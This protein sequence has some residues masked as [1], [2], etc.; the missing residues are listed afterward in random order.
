LKEFTP[1][2]KTILSIEDDGKTNNIHTAKFAS[3]SQNKPGK[4]NIKWDTGSIEEIDL[5]RVCMDVSKR[6]SRQTNHLGFNEDF[7]MKTSHAD[8]RKMKR[9]VKQMKPIKKVMKKVNTTKKITP[10]KKR[11]VTGSKKLPTRK[12]GKMAQAADFGITTIKNFNHPVMIEETEDVYYLMHFFGDQILIKK[13]RFSSK[14]RV[15]IET[16]TRDKVS[17]IL[18]ELFYTKLVTRKGKTFTYEDKSK[19]QQ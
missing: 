9:S 6:R 17:S 10:K 18:Y 1:S 16:K 19:S 14:K 2:N 3:F 13:Q 5:S 7:T 4:I 12:K 15:R 8:E 11:H